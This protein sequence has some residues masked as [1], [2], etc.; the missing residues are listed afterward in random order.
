MDGLHLNS[1]FCVNVRSND[2]KQFYPQIFLPKLLESQ[3]GSRVAEHAG[4]GSECN[5]NICPTPHQTLPKQVVAL[6]AGDSTT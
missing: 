4:R 6:L 2:Y 1:D 5:I 3:P